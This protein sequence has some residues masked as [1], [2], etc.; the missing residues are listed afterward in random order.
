LW[1]LEIRYFDERREQRQVWVAGGEL[2]HAV[3]QIG[4]YGEN[5]A[6]LCFQQLLQGVAYIHSHSITHRD[7]KLENLLLERPGDISRIR[8]VD[9]GLAKGR[10]SG[11]LLDMDTVCGTPGY[12]APEIIAVRW[13]P[14]FSAVL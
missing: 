7:L 5:D 11:N 14:S 13:P 8:I 12:V 4:S 6:R 2:L 9:F 1:R 3:A 10:T